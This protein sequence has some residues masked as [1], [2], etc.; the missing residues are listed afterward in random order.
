MIKNSMI[1]SEDKILGR[2]HWVF[3]ERDVSL[4]I[5][6]GRKMP[7]VIIHFFL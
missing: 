7:E 6:V 5:N 3:K 4:I 1:V 2:R